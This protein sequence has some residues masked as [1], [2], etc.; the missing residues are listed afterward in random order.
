MT[1]EDVIIK[2]IEFFNSTLRPN[3]NKR[4]LKHRY[5]TYN[6]TFY[7]KY[8]M[9][10]AKVIADSIGP[11]EDRLTTLEVVFPRYILAEKN[12]HR[13]LGKNSASSRAIPYKK[14]VKEVLERPFIP[15]AFQK[16]H[17]GMQGT[18]YFDN[19]KKYKLPEFANALRNVFKYTE[20]QI[21]NRFED[22]EPLNDYIINVLE[23]YCE[24][25]LK[26]TDWWLLARDKAVEA[27]IMI[28]CLGITKQLA[29]RLLEP[30]MY[31]KVLVSGTEW[32]NFMNLRC[33]SYALLDD[34]D[35]HIEEYAKSRKE[36]CDIMNNRGTTIHYVTDYSIIDWLK[37]NK[38]QADIHMMFLAE[39]IY[40]AMN[41]STPKELK[42]GEWHMPY[43]DNMD[44]GEFTWN[45]YKKNI[46]YKPNFKE[47]S[48]KVEEF[49]HKISIAR[50]A[51]LSY[52]TL[53]A[54]PVIDYE[55]DLKLYDILSKSGHWSPFEHVARVMTRDEYKE[56]IKGKVKL[57][58]D[59]EFQDQFSAITGKTP[60][61]GAIDNSALGW[62]RN[63]RGFIQYR[64]LLDN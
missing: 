61:A 2:V 7:K 60:I 31:H 13:M 9:I 58:N 11:N 17:S 51:R 59:R 53:G 30:F 18:E 54:N 44:L 56:N 50:C 29:N 32:S 23:E 39:A 21:E 34:E 12:T 46:D 62:C 26:L 6:T 49:R 5:F 1:N 38:G 15:Y 45:Y 41:E 20:E 8:N 10:Q 57:I 42:E 19:D 14:M 37:I 24:L 22:E 40:D 43:G 25:E 35:N 64:E 3:E 27:S 36:W 55:A 4:V 16:D 63:Y 47:Y 33:P 28:A 52:Q 48:S